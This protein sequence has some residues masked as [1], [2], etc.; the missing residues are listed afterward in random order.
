MNILNAPKKKKI[1][2]LEAYKKH[3]TDPKFKVSIQ[4]FYFIHTPH[5]VRIEKRTTCPVN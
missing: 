2:Y 1:V 3:F 4:F 5:L